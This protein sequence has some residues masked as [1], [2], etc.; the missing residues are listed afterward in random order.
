MAWT[1]QALPNKAGVVRYRGC[2]RNAEGKIRRQTFD[3][4]KAAERWAYAQEQKVVEGSRR[5][6]ARGRMHW[7]TWCEQWWPTRRMESGTASSQVTLRDNHVLP[8]WGDVPMNRIEHDKIQIWVNG[9]SSKLSASSVR[10]CYYQL[11]ASMKAAVPKV[12]DYTPCYGIRLPTLPSA[13]ERYLTYDEIDV[14][15][16]YF[17]GV[18]RLLVETLLESGM[19]IG[20]AVALHRHR[21]DFTQR[22]IDVVERWDRHAKLIK[23]Y[24]KGKRRRTVPLTDSLAALMGTWF[25]MHPSDARDCGHAH[26]RGSVCRSALVH[27]APRGGVIDQ[28][29]FST[30]IWGTALEM[31]E[32]G[33]A[34]LHDLRHTYAS[35]IV[36][37]GVSLTVLQSLLGHSSITTTQRYAHLLTDNHDAVR[38]ALAMRPEGANEGANSLTQLDTA[39]HN[40]MR[41]NLGR[42]A[43]TGKTDTAR[44]RPAQAGI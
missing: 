12:L 41:R 3:H 21:V 34:R 23:P 36:T 39:R 33:H 27:V 5:D 19:R 1:E 4:K 31:A 9:L 28:Q 22:T 44:Q 40:R 30:R 18:H 15:F 20:E 25:E 7:G 29:D 37:A 35:R 38:A 16:K 13:P 2:Y 24:T 11:S 42:P 43:K 8:R 10:L 32:I 6:P 26:D 14:L 17:D